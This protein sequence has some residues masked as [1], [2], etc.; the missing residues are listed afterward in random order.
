VYSNLAPSSGNRTATR[1]S[2]GATL[3]STAMGGGYDSQV[4]EVVERIVEL[5]KVRVCVS[6]FFFCMLYA[7]WGGALCLVVK[8][9]VQ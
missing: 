5:A 7:I 8:V 3:S 9:E 6:A 1:N 2:L 4:V